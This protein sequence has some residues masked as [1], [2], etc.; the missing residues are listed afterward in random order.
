MSRGPAAR[1]ATPLWIPLPPPPPVTT[2]KTPGHPYR[3]L[4]W[5]PLRERPAPR[6]SA[7]GPRLI[8]TRTETPAP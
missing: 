3:D 7:T 6:P 8:N 5:V 4:P 2:R 1:A